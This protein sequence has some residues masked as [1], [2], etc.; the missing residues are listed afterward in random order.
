MPSSG[1]LSREALVRTDFSE[2]TSGSII[3]VT[4]IGELGKLDVT[5]QL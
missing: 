4:K 2:E 1:M 5:S 3:R